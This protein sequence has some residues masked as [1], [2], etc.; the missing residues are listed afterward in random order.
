MID[1]RNSGFLVRHQMHLLY[2]AA[3]SLLI[4][5]DAIVFLDSSDCKKFLKFVKN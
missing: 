1:I 4:E 3:L 2:Q 5:P